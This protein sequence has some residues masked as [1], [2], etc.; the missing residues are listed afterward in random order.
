[1][2]SI[3]LTAQSYCCDICLDVSQRL[4]FIADHVFNLPNRIPGT[5]LVVFEKYVRTFAQCP[6]AMAAVILLLAAMHIIAG[7]EIPKA[8]ENHILDQGNVFS[9]EIVERMS[10]A[11]RDCAR[12]RDVYVYVV[13][14]PTLKVMPSREREK[15][16][17]LGKATTAAWTKDRVGAV[18]VF[19]DE[20][21][22]VTIG[23]SEEAEKQFSAVAI[24]MVFKDPLFQI[25]KIHLSPFKLEAAA[26]VLVNGFTD[27]KLKADREAQQRRRSRMIFGSLMF[28]AAVIG[29]W[30]LVTWRG[31]STRQRTDASSARSDTR[32]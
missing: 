22:W 25:R 28:L 8:P 3:H 30:G 10:T 32:E 14:V 2:S 12:T 15:L 21:G 23:A 24:N 19:D 29:G 13:T 18:I 6:L 17:A 4:P 9:P 16:E 27:L 1:M 7:D 26:M 5:N 20:A 11:L 31:P